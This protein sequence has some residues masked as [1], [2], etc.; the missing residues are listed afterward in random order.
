MYFTITLISLA[1]SS[2]MLSYTYIYIHAHLFQ[3]KVERLFQ[4][5]RVLDDTHLGYITATDI[6]GKLGS[7]DPDELLELQVHSS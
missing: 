1:I 4:F 7:D 6:Q 5:F 2:I 3:A